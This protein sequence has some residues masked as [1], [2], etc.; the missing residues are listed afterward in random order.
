MKTRFDIYHYD[1]ERGRTH[2]TVSNVALFSTMQEVLKT[3][4]ENQKSA[5]TICSNDTLF[6]PTDKLDSNCIMTMMPFKDID[7]TLAVIRRVYNE[8]DFHPKRVDDDY[9]PSSISDEIH[10]I[11][12][13]SA[14]IVADMSALNANICYK[15]GYAATLKKQAV[16][17][18]AY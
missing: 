16:L 10:S 9:N 18:Q 17:I 4:Q 2:W 8:A 11:V 15:V 1:W 14:Y 3:I 12:R 6:T 5:Y 7:D 13:N